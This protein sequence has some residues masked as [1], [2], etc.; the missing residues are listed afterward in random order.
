MSETIKKEPVFLG[1]EYLGK[2][3]PMESPPQKAID[4]LKRVFC[5]KKSL[6][7]WNAIEKQA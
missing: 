6:V 7:N 5:T 3:Y 2:L 1:F 4:D